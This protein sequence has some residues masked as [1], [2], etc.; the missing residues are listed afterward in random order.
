NLHWIIGGVQGPNRGVRNTLVE[1]QR[2]R[3]GRL[4]ARRNRVEQE[5][6]ARPRRAYHVWQ[7]EF[8]ENAVGV[9]A[10]RLGVAFA[11]GERTIVRDDLARRDA[12][13][14]RIER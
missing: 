6:R 13:D 3:T 12:A 7:I 4:T 14:A 9:D 1:I 5:H 8:P 11:H 2:S 10:E